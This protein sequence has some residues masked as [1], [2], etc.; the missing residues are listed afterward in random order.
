MNRVIISSKA[1]KVFLKDA[2][3]DRFQNEF[4]LRVYCENNKFGLDGIDR[5]L[6]IE[7]KL[8]FEFSYPTKAYRNY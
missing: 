7:H 2:R 5:T 6:D 1:L 4:R 8:A 3:L